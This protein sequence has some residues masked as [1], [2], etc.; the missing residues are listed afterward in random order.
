MTRPFSRVQNYIAKLGPVPE[1]KN[2]IDKKMYENLTTFYARVL[3][4]PPKNLNC[5]NPAR[6]HP[7][8]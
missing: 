4:N 7:F 6:H 1:T 3:L 5:P 8:R 2:F